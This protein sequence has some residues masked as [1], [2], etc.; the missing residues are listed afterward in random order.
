MTNTMAPETLARRS[1]RLITKAQQAEI[2]DILARLA[3]I[4]A[5]T[6]VHPNLAGNESIAARGALAAGSALREALHTDTAER[7][8][9][10]NAETEIAD[11]V[12]YAYDPS[13]T[14]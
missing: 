11:R 1:A 6:G 2:E 13:T 5:E 8:W 7:S 3:A 4:V 12:W 10:N 9:L 14:A